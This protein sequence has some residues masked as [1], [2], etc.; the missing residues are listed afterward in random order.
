MPGTPSVAWKVRPLSE[1]PAFEWLAFFLLCG[2]SSSAWLL[3]STLFASIT[4]SQSQALVLAVG[5]LLALLAG[6]RFTLPDRLSYRVPCLAILLLAVPA[7]LCDQARMGN[8]LT[9]VAIFAM[10]PIGMV[11]P[12]TMEQNEQ[13]SH[14]FLLPAVAG[15]GGL[16]FVLPVELPAG[17]H[18]AES[19][20]MLLAAAGS[21]VF[22][23]ARLPA[24][25]GTVSFRSVVVLVCFPNS[26]LLFSYAVLVR[27]VHPSLPTPSLIPS[28]TL[29]LLQLGLLLRL[30]QTMPSL[31]LA[32]R[33]LVV[34]LLTAAEGYLVLGGP[35]TAR[36]I[37]GALVAAG[38]AAYL[39]FAPPAEKTL[40]LSLR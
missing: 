32:A 8:D 36:M 18:A 6:G 22:S 30:V 40:T 14:K 38:C 37:F 17:I 31:R 5:G 9:R 4:T 7:I 20:A 19:I 39:L 27:H 25:L 12:M 21:V 29:N 34:P 1:T 35:F 2:L 33:F 16:L 10:V 28:A 11:I 13:G 15:L 3:P 24:C 26:V 23:S